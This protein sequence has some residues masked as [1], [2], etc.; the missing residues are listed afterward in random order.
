VPAVRRRL[1]HITLKTKDE[2]LLLCT[3]A[4]AA[5]SRPGM[6]LIGAWLAAETL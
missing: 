3:L 5:F 2:T 6:N 4:H 1:L